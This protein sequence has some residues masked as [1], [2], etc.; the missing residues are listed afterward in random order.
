MTRRKTIM[1]SDELLGPILAHDG[2]LLEAANSER[3]LGLSM[4]WHFL[5]L[6]LG[7]RCAGI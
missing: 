2:F 3:L 5:P 4:S 6:N 7:Y 1:G